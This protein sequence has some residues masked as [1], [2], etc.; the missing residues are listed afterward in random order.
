VWYNDARILVQNGRLLRTDF[1]CN[2]EGCKDLL[3]LQTEGNNSKNNEKYF[4][5]VKYKRHQSLQQR[6][7]C[8]SL[9]AK[10]V[11]KKRSYISL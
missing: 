3:I 7:G 9:R 4:I 1:H 10:I 2:G 6:M 8:K 5:I 11:I